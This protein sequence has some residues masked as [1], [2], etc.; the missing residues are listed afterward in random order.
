MDPL[1]TI[2]EHTA[3]VFGRTTQELLGRSRKQ[4]IIEARQAAMWAVR[5]RYPS[6]PLQGIGSAIGGRHYTTVMH[7]LAAVEVRGADDPAYM[8][9]LNLLLARIGTSGA[10]PDPST[11]VVLPRTASLWLCR[12]L[13]D[14]RM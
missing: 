6:I 5:K 13:H 9:R 7:A 8:D 12:A 3:N 14:R 4:P 10:P 2:V 11:L 1:R